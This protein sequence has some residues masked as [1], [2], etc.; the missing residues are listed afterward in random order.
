MTQKTFPP[1][2]DSLVRQVRRAFF[3]GAAGI[4][5]IGLTVVGLGALDRSLLRSMYESRE[6][7][8]MARQAQLLANDRET[9]LRG[10]LLTGKEI[11]LAPEIEGRK[12]LK[13]KLDSLVQLTK[14]SPARQDR[15]L[16]ISR[17][18]DRW[19]RGY[20]APALA[21]VAEAR[22]S[23]AVSLAG[24]EL[25]DSIRSAFGSFLAAEERLYRQRVQFE[26]FVRN[27]STGAVV[28]LIALILLLMVWLNRRVVAQAREMV[29]QQETLEDQAVELEHQAAELEEQAIQLEE[30]NASG[31]VV[32]DSL[33][34]ANAELATTVENLEKLRDDQGKTLAE[35]VRAESLL[36]FVLTSSPV[37]FGLLD[38]TCAFTLANE[39]MAKFLGLPLSDVKGKRP[40]DLVAPEMAADSEQW[41]RTV[42]ETGQPITNVARV[43]PILPDDQA[44]KHWLVGYFPVESAHRGRPGV[45]VVVHDMTDRH[46]LEDRLIQAQTMEAVGRLAGGVAHDFNNMLTAIKSYGDLVLSEMADDS[47]QRPDVIEI[48]KAADRAAAL[49]RQ[50]LAFSRQQVLRPEIIDMNSVVNDMQKMLKSLVGA[51]VTIVTRLRAEAGSVN[52]DPAEIERVIVNLV[53]NA[54]DA[55]SGKGTITIETADAEISE[56]DAVGRGDMRPGPHVMLAVSDTGT[57]MTKEVKDKLFEP[58]FTT[59]ERGKGTGLGLSSIYGIVKQSE[60]HIWVYSEPG[61]GTTFKIYLPRKQ[62][63][64]NDHKDPAERIDL[65]ETETI[66]LVEDDEVVRG[67]V[68]RVLRRAGFTVLQAGNGKDAID[69]YKVDGFSVDLVI[70]DII[71]PQM[72]GA[73]LAT[74]IREID[75]GAKILFTSGYTEDK[76]MRDTLLCPGAE[77]LEKPFTPA[78][79]AAKAREVL[80]KVSAA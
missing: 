54:R 53:I 33:I 1:N 56:P 79:V 35:R 15:A 8:R 58:F 21:D 3:L 41:I 24:K 63:Q 48:N 57:G 52:A 28:F 13:P 43:G 38:D 50:L 67:V 4:V 69:L 23:S 59:K 47:P 37:G 26:R 60:G 68:A 65:I 31:R 5:V 2:R 51:D 72:G 44:R 45:G 6:V 14:D 18:I 78:S 12:K 27:A 42:L 61:E 62:S 49:T 19:E 30:E 9:E 70:T 20:L 74:K 10:F 75:P 40:R 64:T 55:M 39:A 29:A 73:E 32:S 7:T 11:S 80:D 16:A 76:V 17:S 46:Q 34:L 25:F 36:N 22:K 71:M 66:L 77:F